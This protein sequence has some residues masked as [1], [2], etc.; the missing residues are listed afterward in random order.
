[1]GISKNTVKILILMAVLYKITAIKV[2]YFTK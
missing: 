2:E 1:M